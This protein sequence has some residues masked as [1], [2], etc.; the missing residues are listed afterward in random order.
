MKVTDFLGQHLAHDIISHATNDLMLA[1][2]RCDHGK[3][4][5]LVPIIAA[6]HWLRNARARDRA[7]SR[8]ELYDFHEGSRSALIG[9]YRWIH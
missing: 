2:E 5:A 1:A 6:V 8:N 7:L 9:Y 3:G 4:G